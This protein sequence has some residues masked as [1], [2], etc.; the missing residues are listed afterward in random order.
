MPVPQLRRTGCLVPSAA[1]APSPRPQPSSLRRRICALW[2]VTLL[3]GQPYAP[4]LLP[5]PLPIA[6]EKPPVILGLSRAGSAL[7]PAAAIRAPLRRTLLTA[8]RALNV[9]PTRGT[10]SPYH[11]I[12]SAQFRVL[13]L[14][15]LRFPLPLAPRRCRCHGELDPLGD[16]RSAC[17]TSGVLATRALP[18]EHAVAR[19]CREA[20][21]RVAR[22]V[23][24]A[25]MNLDVP[26]SDERRIEV[27]A[28]GLPLWH[29]S[30]LA[31][32]ATIVCPL[33]RRGESSR[34]PMSSRGRGSPS[35]QRP[36]ANGIR[37]TPSSSMRG[38]AGW[39]LLGLRLA[40]G[41]VPRPYSCCASLH[42]TGPLPSLRTCGPPQLSPGSRAGLGSW[43]SPPSA[44]RGLAP[45]AAACCRARRGTPTRPA[46]GLGRL[47]RRP[48]VGSRL[49]VNVHRGGWD[50]SRCRKKAR[51]KKRS[52]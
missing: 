27:V 5:R 34:M 51:E 17:A 28:N 50:S 38:A 13:L 45:R 9:L 15:R 46:R 11:A 41:S 35:P 20:G 16:H 31:L 47:S 14:R 1:T 33:T 42:D 8:A 39:L 21:A 4:A 43:L 22:H 24:L 30:Q 48:A 3:T 52:L 19:V 18:L 44:P 40:A 12:P 36:G 6:L 10:R 2:A 25:D 29:G 7:L 26:V 32:D 23:R 37:P 49:L